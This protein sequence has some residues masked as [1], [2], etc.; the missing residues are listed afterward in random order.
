MMYRNFWRWKLKRCCAAT[1][2]RRGTDGWLRQNHTGL[3]HGRDLDM[4]AIYLPAGPMLRGNW[5]GKTLGSGTDVWKYWAE[6]CA[7]N[8]SDCDWRKWKTASP[9]RRATA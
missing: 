6:K 3:V 8:I 7:G 2:G 5:N 4:P 9:G 1:R